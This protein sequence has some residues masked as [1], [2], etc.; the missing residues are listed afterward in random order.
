MPTDGLC[1]VSP[2]MPPLAA[3]RCVQLR[4]PAASVTS[5]PATD[6]DVTRASLASPHWKAPHTSTSAEALQS[7]PLLSS[8]RSH[9][10]RGPW[11]P[12]HGCQP[13]VSPRVAGY[14]RRG[15]S[16]CATPRP[17]PPPRTLPPVR[18][19]LVPLQSPPRAV[20]AAAA[21]PVVPP[22]SH[23]G[24]ATSRTHR[25]EGRRRCPPPPTRHGAAR[26]VDVPLEPSPQRPGATLAR[27]AC[28]PP[29]S[30]FTIRATASCRHPVA[31]WAAAVQTPGADTSPAPP[32]PQL[33]APPRRVPTHRFHRAPPSIVPRAPPDNARPP[34][35]PP[36]SSHAANT[37]VLVETRSRCPVTAQA[38]GCGGGG[39]LDVPRPARSPRICT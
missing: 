15:F 16:H 8:L 37:P 32:P 34:P 13:P 6:R 7:S 17:L 4:P 21:T 36:A 11:R 19:R 10:R 5:T 24:A 33:V 23:D 9:L 2:G 18:P 28:R 26:P 27:H 39:R 14:A 35:S 12:A 30:F 29:R 25:R 3:V 1:H 20:R 38:A 31:S 22:N